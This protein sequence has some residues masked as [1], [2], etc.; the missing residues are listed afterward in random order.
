MLTQ[1]QIDEIV[2][3]SLQADE[4]PT[5]LVRRVE[6]ALMR[7]VIGE[8]EMATPSDFSCRG[9]SDESRAVAEALQGLTDTLNSRWRDSLIP[10]ETVTAVKDALG[11]EL[12]NMLLNCP[13]NV[14]THGA[15]NWAIS[16]AS[17]LT[18]LL[19]PFIT[20]PSKS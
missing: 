7:E 15:A 6:A 2:N 5:Q 3:A 16:R 19:A 4:G 9:M 12:G 1:R 13:R 8:C 11:H 20:P 18:E 17:R 10:R 14:G